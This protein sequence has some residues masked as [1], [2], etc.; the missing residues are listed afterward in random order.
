[1]MIDESS[2]VVK[3]VSGVEIPPRHAP[4]SRVSRVPFKSRYYE[5]AGA[6]AIGHRLFVIGAMRSFSFK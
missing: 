2:N 5:A 6:F 3:A 1:M 4:N